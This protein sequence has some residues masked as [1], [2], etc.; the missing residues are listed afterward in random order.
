VPPLT[1]RRRR[2]RWAADTNDLMTPCW[3]ERTMV[4]VPSDMVRA[5]RTVSCGQRR[6]KPDIGV[7]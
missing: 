3:C 6:C 4:F 7:S 1:L 5:G 2:E